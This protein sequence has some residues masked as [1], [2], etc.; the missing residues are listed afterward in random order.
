LAKYVGLLCQAEFDRVGK[1]CETE[2]KEVELNVLVHRGLAH[3]I[4]TM[5]EFCDKVQQWPTVRNQSE[6]TMHW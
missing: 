4:A 3:N 2:E 1:S 6:T 5:Q